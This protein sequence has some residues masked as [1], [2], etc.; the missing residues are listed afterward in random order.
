MSRLS[1]CCLRALVHLFWTPTGRARRD[2]LA[3]ASTEAPG[4]PSLSAVGGGSACSRQ[5]TSHQPRKPRPR[6]VS[7][8]SPLPAQDIDV[9]SRHHPHRRTAG[10]RPRPS[11][12]K[13]LCG[14]DRELGSVEQRQPI[15]DDFKAPLIRHVWCQDL[16]VSDNH[17][18]ADSNANPLRPNTPTM[19]HVAH[20]PHPIARPSLPLSSTVYW[21]INLL[22]NPRRN[23][24]MRRR[25]HFLD[26]PF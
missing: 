11:Q 22:K 9:S 4:A 8:R 21:N 25:L 24:F 2:A 26:C 6:T 20:R 19:A 17:V 12:R 10:E 14:V 15:R 3:A 13:H 5:T 7:C 23:L 1:F 16:Q 18:L